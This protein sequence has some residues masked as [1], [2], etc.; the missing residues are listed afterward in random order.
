M[1][2]KSTPK[3]EHALSDVEGLIIFPN[4]LTLL[5][6]TKAEELQCSCTIVHCFMHSN[7]TIRIE[8]FQHS[9]QTVTLLHEVSLQ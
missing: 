5:L 3:Q 2:K 4:Y 1:E 7:V 6:K 8:A 9:T